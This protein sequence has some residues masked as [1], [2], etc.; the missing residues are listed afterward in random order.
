ML[1]FLEVLSEPGVYQSLK[2]TLKSGKVDIQGADPAFLF[3]ATALKP[4]PIDVDV[5]CGRM[6]QE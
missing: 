1:S 6:A 3:T 4:E 2:R 5:R